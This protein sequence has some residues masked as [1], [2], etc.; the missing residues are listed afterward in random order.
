MI[1]RPESQKKKQKNSCA[2]Q[3][4]YWIWWKSVGLISYG[5]TKRTDYFR[6][7]FE[8]RYGACAVRTSNGVFRLKTGL[9]VE[10]TTVPHRRNFG[11]TKGGDVLNK[12]SNCQLPLW[13][14]LVGTATG[15]G[16]DRPGFEP[17]GEEIFQNRPDQPCGPPIHLYKWIAFLFSRGKATAA[18]G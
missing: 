10:V 1:I 8:Y 17:N 7:L 2:P 6:V 5:C 18:W 15:Y 16:L 4:L 13:K 12:L 3:C 14:L 11:N 9:V